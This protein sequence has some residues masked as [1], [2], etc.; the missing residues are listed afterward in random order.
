MDT[1]P[2]GD[3]ERVRFQLRQRLEALGR[4]GLDRIPVVSRRSGD[5]LTSLP[6]RPIAPTPPVLTNAVDRPPPDSSR[7]PERKAQSRIDEPDPMRSAS[8]GSGLL[9]GSDLAAEVPLPERPAALAVLADEVSGCQRC[10][11]LVASRSRTVF[12]EGNPA[13]RLMFIGEAPGADED[14]TGR[15]FVGRAGQLLTDMIT[16]GMRLRREDVYIANV[17]KC[18]PPDNR[19]PLPDEVAQCR[20]YLERQV[21]IIRPERICLLGKTAAAA[22]IDGAASLP[23]SKLRGRWFEVYGIRAL[24]TYHPAYLLRN[25]AS[26][27]EAWEDLKALMSE[28]GLKPAAT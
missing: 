5:V 26:K 21:G 15:P 1:Q 4:A 16:K 10:P 25:P 14:R 17:L 6:S 8:V 23:M 12:G 20:G 13:A 7:S 22:L 19:T 28:L 11:Q 24:V 9:F 18:R 27:R 3:L 2:D